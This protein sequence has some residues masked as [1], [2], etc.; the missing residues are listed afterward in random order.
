MNLTEGELKQKLKNKEDFIL[1]D[2]REDSEREYAMIP[3]SIHI[4]LA[5]LPS[6]LAVLDK[7]KEIVVYCH[8][9]GR[10]AYATMFLKEKGFN[11][12]NLTGGI[13]AWSDIDKNIKKY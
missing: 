3:G 11:A 1:L 4:R 5:D 10:S 2:V 6:S 8:T 12:M 7:E 13:D 9:G